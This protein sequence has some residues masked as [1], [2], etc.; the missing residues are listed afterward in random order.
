M[1]RAMP[2][3]PEVDSIRIESGCRPPARST[4]ATISAAAFSFVDPA[5]LR[6]SHLR[7]IGRRS[8][9]RRSMNR[10]SSISSWGAVITGILAYFRLS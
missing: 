1:L 2:M 4:M 10:S 3:L 5:K 7:K 6:P 8:R 9:G